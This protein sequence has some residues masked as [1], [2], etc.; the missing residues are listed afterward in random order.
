MEWAFAEPYIE[1][2]GKTNPYVLC[3]L[4]MMAA[5]W[6]KKSFLMGSVVHAGVAYNCVT[7]Q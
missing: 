4:K 3:A 7:T 2:G 6:A 5:S 1:R